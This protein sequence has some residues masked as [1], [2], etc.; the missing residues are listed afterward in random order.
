MRQKLDS[1]SGKTTYGKRKYTF[2]PPLGHIKS[3]ME[4]TSFL[5]RG[6]QKVKGKFKIVSIAHNLR[7]ICLYLKANKKKPVRNV[8]GTGVLTQVLM[9]KPQPVSLLI[10]YRPIWTPSG[11]GT[12]ALIIK[13]DNLVSRQQKMT[14]SLK[15]AAGQIFNT[16]IKKSIE[17]FST[18][19]N[20]YIWLML[21]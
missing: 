10:C 7:K 19:S 20:S 17:F 4:F 1:E 12:A 5:L 14:I 16:V 6:K 3:I 11:C 2:E 13:I 18:I 9:S 8:P 21:F 15:M